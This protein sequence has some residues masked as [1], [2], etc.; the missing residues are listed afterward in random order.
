M[1]LR[2]HAGEGETWQEA[3]AAEL[4]AITERLLTLVERDAEIYERVVAA[5]ELDEGPERTQALDKALRA[6]LDTPTEMM[7]ACLGGLRIAL[8]GAEAGVPKHLACDCLAG[9]QALW[10]GVE[11][12][13]LMVR[14]NA[15]LM[16]GD[17][18]TRLLLEN[19]G[20]MRV[21][22]AKLLVK[23]RGF[24]EGRAG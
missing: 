5:R 3:R 24:T 19:A 23:V 8:R 10:V 17:E 13:F 4:D 7:E 1:T 15:G 16:E 2:S 11:D 22:A 18:D 9:T 21:E 14:D 20:A 12:A 6:A